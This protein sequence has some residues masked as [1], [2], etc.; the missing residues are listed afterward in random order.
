MIQLKTQT[1]PLIF[2]LFGK[3]ILARWRTDED[4]MSFDLL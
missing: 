1:P 3:V 2:E 4:R